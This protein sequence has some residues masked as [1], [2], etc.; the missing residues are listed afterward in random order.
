MTEP[1]QH[2]STNA[3]KP[4]AGVVRISRSVRSISEISQTTGK[5]QIDR[6]LLL[7][8]EQMQVEF[9]ETPVEAEM[10]GNRLT[11]NVGFAFRTRPRAED[12]ANSL[13]TTMAI[14][15]SAI[16]VIR[17]DVGELDPVPT[18][19]ELESFGEINGRFNATSYWREYL[20]NCLVR[21]GL[22]PIT[23]Q[24]FNA[25]ERLKKLDEPKLEP[26]GTSRSANDAPA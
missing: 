2:P 24:P 13:A 7:D 3:P 15:V 16:Y 1:S 21:A 10:D 14:F 22:P 5:F 8:G 4:S 25:A 19:D 20:N 11:V 12:A 17:Y 9:F 18:P 6:S 23:V 26:D